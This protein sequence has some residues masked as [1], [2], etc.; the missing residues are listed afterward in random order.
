MVAAVAVEKTMLE[1]EKQ[2]IVRKNLRRF[3]DTRQSRV[4]SA[5]GEERELSSTCDVNQVDGPARDD[6][7]TEEA[8]APAG[9]EDELT[10]GTYNRD[11][12]FVPSEGEGC[13]SHFFSTI[14]IG[15]RQA[16]TDVMSCST[17]KAC[18]PGDQSVEILPEALAAEASEAAKEILEKTAP[19]ELEMAS[20]EVRD[21]YYKTLSK[22]AITVAEIVSV[23]D[24]ASPSPCF[25]SSYLLTRM[26]GNFSGEEKSRA[27]D[28]EDRVRKHN[29]RRGH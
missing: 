6:A 4:A 29:D 20:A 25:E 10:L 28:E 27:R 18:D 7:T 16:A 26:L 19:V 3:R 22:A 23:L 24:C 5:A 11:K 13:V 21:E 15:A 1:S 8:P 14:F 12:S 9:D 2:E 17:L